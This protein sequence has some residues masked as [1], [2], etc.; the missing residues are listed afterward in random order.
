MMMFFRPASSK[1]IKAREFARNPGIP[2]SIRPGRSLGLAS[3]PDLCPHRGS[4]HDR[5]SAQPDS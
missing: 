3:P 2:H 4:D 5:M 1:V